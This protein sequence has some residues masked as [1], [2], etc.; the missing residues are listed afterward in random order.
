MRALLRVAVPA[1]LLGGVIGATATWWALREHRSESRIVS[2]T[3]QPLDAPMVSLGPDEH[4]LAIAPNGRFVVFA[5]STPERPRGTLLVDHLDGQPPSLLFSG[6]EGLSPRSPF[7]SPDSRWVGFISEGTVMKVAASG[8]E[9]SVVC[10]CGASTAGG[11]AWMP[12]GALVFQAGQV[13]R[14]LSADGRQRRDLTRLDPLRNERA[15]LAPKP[16]P[17]GTD[18][19]FTVER[20]R[21]EEGS[22]DAV[23]LRTGVRRRILKGGAFGVVIGTDALVYVVS[24][25]HL[26]ALRFDP[27]TFEPLGPSTAI[28]AGTVH[29]EPG[30]SPAF[31]VS[32]TG[33][34]AYAR[35]TPVL[36]MRGLYWVTRDGEE[37]VAARDRHNF[38]YPRISPHGD[39]VA[40]DIRDPGNDNVWLLDTESR[41]L[42][43]VT[44]QG[45]HGSPVWTPDGRTLLITWGRPRVDALARLD[46]EKPGPVTAV[47]DHPRSLLPSIVSRD[48]R[49][50]IVRESIGAI[51]TLARISLG[52]PRAPEEVASVPE[53]SVLNG[54]L[55][56]DGRWLAYQANVSTGM[57]VMVRR[58]DVPGAPP[59]Q[60]S[61]RG[62]SM[63]V[64]SRDGRE[65]LFFDEAFE[66]TRVEVSQAG[67]DLTFGAP[68]RFFPTHYSTSDWFHEARGRTF[69][70]SPDGSRLLF[71][72]AGAASDVR[73]RAPLTVLA[74]GA[75]P[76]SVGVLARARQRIAWVLRE[77][78]RPRRAPPQG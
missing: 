42:R 16:L 59:R 12:D 54:E 63:P 37:T 4:P 35:G 77:M 31:D 57:H 23:N 15:H 10:V 14:W 22:I 66:L 27:S 68:S 40:I 34:L 39:R 36:R 58:L 67:P 41:Q 53:G 73:A 51:T 65:I 43:Q 46:V 28:D 48:G 33:T 11:A 5:A 78:R 20:S 29:I 72:R 69:D 55:S 3:A 56:P 64:W 44:Q 19:V 75:V 32:Q 45:R 18:V 38:V 8:G 49:L 61:A 47:I 60:L 6:A 2:G 24:D 52:Q 30:G 25:G 21:F 26:Q 13:L 74:R 9:P 7:I 76:P 50:V 70:L 1:L 71:S 17:S 62:G